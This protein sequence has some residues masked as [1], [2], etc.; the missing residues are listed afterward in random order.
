MLVI[1]LVAGVA[2]LGRLLE[3]GVLVAFLALGIHVLAQQ[4]EAG[5]VVVELGGLFPAA[6]TVATAAVLAQRF[7]VFVVGLVTRIAVLTQLDSVEMPG[8]A[9]VALGAAV[10]ATQRVL[11]I[12]V[13]IEI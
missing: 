7:F 13:V 8:V 1:L 2:I 3:H 11:G 10:L 4:G 6:L 5:Q 12:R 9:L